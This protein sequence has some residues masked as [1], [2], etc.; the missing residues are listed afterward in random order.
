MAKEEADRVAEEN[1]KAAEL[2]AA[3][4]AK[5]APVLDEAFGPAVAVIEPTP[6]RVFSS[7]LNQPFGQSFGDVP[8]PVAPKPKPAPISAPVK[9]GYGR[10]SSFVT[11]WKLT[12]V[13]DFDALYLHLKNL[14]EVQNVLRERAAILVRQ[15]T[16]V[17]PGC[18]IEEDVAST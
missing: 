6:T 17:I 7:V 9:P 1:R 11:V 12:E 4:A 3:E 14:P 18:K 5:Q 16:H 10:A 2:A 8:A 13:T 15:G